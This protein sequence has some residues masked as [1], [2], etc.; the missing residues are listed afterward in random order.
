MLPNW[1]EANSYLP[2]LEKAF[3]GRNVHVLRPAAID[4]PHVDRRLAAQGSHFVIFGRTQDLTKIK[5]TS[6][7]RHR[8]LRQLSRIIIDRRSSHDLRSELELCGITGPLLFPDLQ[9]LCDDISRKCL[10]PDRV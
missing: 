2:D 9:A 6:S 4:P 5:T 3:S 7:A 10:N 1:Q 8:K